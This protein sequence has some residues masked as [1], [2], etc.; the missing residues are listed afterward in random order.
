LG[1]PP[2]VA[3]G[4]NRIAI[5]MSTSSA[6]LGFKSKG[7][8]T[9]PFNIYLGICGLLGAFIGAK[10]AI[11]IDG[12]LF[13]KI[14]AIIMIGVVVLIVFKPKVNY[15]ELVERL[16]G[17]HLYIS[18]I[19]FFFIGIYGGFINAGIGF[20]IML[21]L[22]YYNRLNLVKVNSA[23]VVIVLIYT[24]GALITF[25]LADKVNWTYGLFLASGNFLGGWS[26]S[27]WSVKKGENSIKVF[28]IVIVVLMS[29]KLWF[30]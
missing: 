4:T 6:T 12:A 3:N 17:K 22:H 10:I 16:T 30:F 24:T 14:L 27:R 18:M 21:F 8:S 29:I 28:L 2:A 23:K 15:T 19:V 5:F 20:V 26:S 1:L 13:N 11:D 25:A 9:F 7:V